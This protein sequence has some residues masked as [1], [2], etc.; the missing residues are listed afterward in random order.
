MKRWYVVQ[1]KYNQEL[2]AVE[3]LRNQNFE[4]FFP[5]YQKKRQDK[6]SG[7][8]FDQTLP[9][10]PSYV[11]VKF[12]VEGCRWLKIASTRGVKSFVGYTDDYLSPLPQGCVE[13]IIARADQSGVV[14]IVPVFEDLLKFTPNM[15]LKIKN[16]SLAGL[17][18]TYCNHSG[19][20]VVLLLT[21]LNQKTRVSLPIHTVT[22]TP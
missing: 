12:D 10:F 6:K 4:T 21:L 11:F 13:E 8:I 19:N 7:I 2:L 3:N 5:V 14:P 15:K 20:R 17:V 1:T 22:R 16:G 9:L 18:G